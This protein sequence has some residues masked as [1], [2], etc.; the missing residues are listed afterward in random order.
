[1]KYKITLGGKVYE[2]EVEKGNATL[3]DEYEAKLP[4]PSSAP[5]AQ[6]PAVQAPVAAPAIP[7]TSGGKPIASPLPGVVVAIKKNVG[8]KVKRNE[9]IAVIE[10]MKMENDVTSTE[11]GTVTA[12]LVTKGASIQQGTPLIEVK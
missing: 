12:V 10:A 3:L 5:V 1:M 7:Q 9:V 2:V 8:D 11:E 4:T 6:S